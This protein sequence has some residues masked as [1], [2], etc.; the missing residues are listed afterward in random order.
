[1]RTQSGVQVYFVETHAL[2][3]VDV[4]VEFAAGSAYDPQERAGLGQLTLA[5][6]KGG[7]ARYSEAEVDRRIADAGAQLRDNFDL[8]R[9]GFALRTLSSE[10]ERKAATETLADF[11]QAPRFAGDIFEREKARAIANVAEADT[12]P[13]QVAEK[14][15][16]A[17][18][19]PAHPYGWTPTKATLAAVSREDVERHYRARYRSAG[20]A[21]TIVGDLSIAAAKELA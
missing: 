20:A 9:A 5:L 1:W 17:L 6:L 13:D 19:Y 4:S 14:R 8:D 18:M 15:L 21:V 2:P 7:S 16:Y 12:Q 3:I 11:V 10:A